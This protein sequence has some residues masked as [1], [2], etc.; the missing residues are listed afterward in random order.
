MKKSWLHTFALTLL[1]ITQSIMAITYNDIVKLPYIGGSMLYNQ[2]DLSKSQLQVNND[3]AVRLSLLK[4]E[5]VPI[6]ELN[7]LSQEEKQELY[8]DGLTH[9]ELFEEDENSIEYGIITINSINSFNIG[10]T[11][12]MYNSNGDL[13]ENHT[14]TIMVDQ[15]ADLNYDGYPDI[16]YKASINQYYSYET[17][18][19]YLRFVSSNE[20]LHTA[21]FSYAPDLQANLQDFGLL[22]FNPDGNAIYRPAIEENDG[23]FGVL[24]KVTTNQ[25]SFDF[26]PGDIIFDYEEGKYIQMTGS[27]NTG[28]LPKL[29]DGGIT[30]EELE[31]FF[32][33]V[34]FHTGYSVP[35]E[36]D[37]DNYIG[38]MANT[39][40]QF[41]N[42]VSEYEEKLDD[43][44]L[45]LG[46]I[47]IPKAVENVD[48]GVF[49]FGLRDGKISIGIGASFKI[50]WS[51]IGIKNSIS[52][53]AMIQGDMFASVMENVTLEDD[54]VIFKDYTGPLYSSGH[55]IPKRKLTLYTAGL[56][57]E[58]VFFVGPIPLT[59]GIN[60]EAGAEMS[61]VLDKRS[62]VGAKFVAY[63]DF[64]SKTRLT[65][66]DGMS[67]KKSF[68]ASFDFFPYY[69]FDK[70]VSLALNFTPYYKITPYITLAKVVAALNIN[71][72]IKLPNIWQVSAST[73]DINIH[74]NLDL[75][76]VTELEVILGYKFKLPFK[77]IDLSKGISFEV[78]NY[79]IPLSE[80]DLTIPINATTQSVEGSVLT[81]NDIILIQQKL[82]T[83]PLKISG[84]SI[85]IIDQVSNYTLKNQL[86]EE[87]YSHKRGIVRD[88]PDENFE[89]FSI[90]MQTSNYGDAYTRPW[91]NVFSHTFDQVGKYT[92]W[93]KTCF[94]L[95]YGLD[96]ECASM[97]INVIK[98][99]IVPT[100]LTPL[101]L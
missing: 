6:E 42:K 49:S 9:V 89:E 48:G 82:I 28:A 91:D 46:P 31:L 87:L 74:Y 15:Q 35:P 2:N 20:N 94:L 72:Y 26:K 24:T 40:E 5:Q 52:F 88:N 13:L 29:S 71:Q 56:F 43:G 22:G 55:T 92:L 73:D 95:D 62:R 69:V 39:E 99:P 44:R 101:L 100:I 54:E 78:F 8:D 18:K 66:R 77:T 53:G 16:E 70:N 27:N 98:F 1:L 41:S 4:T 14:Y 64:E 60:Q 61:V 23:G 58:K 59:I 7:A 79:P 97:D 11:C 51:K 81:N 33:T 75:E 30:L 86:I 84:S 21:M 63:A 47:P 83:L 93:A 67:F 45:I 90:Y 32:G 50:L 65:L 57:P 85:A 68:S 10:F 25:E 36:D 3:Y 96:C 12:K 76:F 80:F 34:S 38:N 19:L 17:G 37:N